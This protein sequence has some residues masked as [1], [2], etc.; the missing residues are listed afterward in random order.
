MTEETGQGIRCSQKF[1]DEALKERKGTEKLKKSSQGHKRG[2]RFYSSALSCDDDG[3]GCA[4]V[5]LMRGK[6]I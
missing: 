3:Y 4:G 2:V 5:W 6:L 1:D